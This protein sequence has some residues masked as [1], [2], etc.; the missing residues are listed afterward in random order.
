M[1]NGPEPQIHNGFTAIHA[2]H[3]LMHGEKGNADIL[4][5]QS[6]IY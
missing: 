5:L 2:M 1:F 4:L 6:Y 3:G